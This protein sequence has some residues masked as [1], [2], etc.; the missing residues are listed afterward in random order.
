MWWQKANLRFIFLVEALMW[1]ALIRWLSRRAPWNH[2]KV[3]NIRQK[4][5]TRTDPPT[6]GG[7]W[8]CSSR[9]E[10]QLVTNWIANL[11]FSKNIYVVVCLTAW[12][13]SLSHKYACRKRIGN[14][15]LEN[16]EE[17]LK[18]LLYIY[19][20]IYIYIYAIYVY[21]VCYLKTWS[22]SIIS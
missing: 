2:F 14:T 17:N 7:C 11:I 19:I 8:R 4:A 3:E 9:S 22:V 21:I 1:L 10:S 6:G 15:L 18:F 13:V 16:I 20:Y 5:R 12:S